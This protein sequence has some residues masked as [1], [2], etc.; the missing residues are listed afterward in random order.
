MTKRT[1]R[2]E[3]MEDMVCGPQPDQLPNDED[4]RKRLLHQGKI[5]Q[6]EF[7]SMFQCIMTTGETEQR[8]IK[9]E[10]GMQ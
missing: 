2:T 10:Q 5:R 4:V 3:D 1:S 9:N 6:K 7:I 8:A